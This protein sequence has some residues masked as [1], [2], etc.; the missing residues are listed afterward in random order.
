MSKELISVIFGWLP[1]VVFL[2][3]LVYFIRKGNNYYKKYDQHIADVLNANAELVAIN[4]EMA[5]TLVEIRTLLQ[6]GKS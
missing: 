3:F 1:L 2:G 5:Q 4:K 6:T